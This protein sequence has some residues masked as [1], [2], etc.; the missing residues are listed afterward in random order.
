[1]T[2]TDKAPAEAGLTRPWPA[3][4]VER[5]PIERLAVGLDMDRIRQGPLV[6]IHLPPAESRLQTGPAG[7]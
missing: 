1:M 4:Q 5:W 6:R 7:R 2:V 3:D